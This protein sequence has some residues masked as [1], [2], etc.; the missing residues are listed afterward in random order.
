VKSPFIKKAGPLCF[1]YDLL[2]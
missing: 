2:L 1:W